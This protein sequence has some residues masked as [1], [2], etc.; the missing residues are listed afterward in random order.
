MN[1]RCQADLIDMQSE[2]DGCYRFI[3]NH[4]NH[5]TNFKILL[6]LKSNTTQ[7]VAYQ[8]MDIFCMF[9]ATFI[10]QNDNGLEF[11]NKI[12]QNMADM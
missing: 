9:I 1:S 2:P 4:Q 7:D 3:K 10:L 8:L 5:L 11:M 12:I 6:P